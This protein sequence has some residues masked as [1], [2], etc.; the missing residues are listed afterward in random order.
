MHTLYIRNIPDEAYDR[1]RALASESNA[2][3]AS[4]AR[5]SLE[6]GLA[7]ARIARAQWIDDLLAS[8]PRVA[9]DADVAALIRADRDSR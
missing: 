4:I 6:R 5:E 1:L 3:I 9:D 2:S 7:T 8:R